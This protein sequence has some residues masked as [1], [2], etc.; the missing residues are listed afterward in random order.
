M[1]A[2]ISKSSSGATVGAGGVFGTRGKLAGVGG[3]VGRGRSGIV[4]G[5]SKLDGVAWPDII[6]FFAGRAPL[7]KP[8]A[9][10]VIFRSSFKASSMTA[11]KIIFAVGSADWVITRAAS[12]T[13][14]I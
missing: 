6:I 3:G 10:T 5:A 9:M 8:V 7:P 2:G 13:S 14:Y 12:F 11:P 1:K 4:T